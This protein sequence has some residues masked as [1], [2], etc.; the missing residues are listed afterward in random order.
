MKITNNMHCVSWPNIS[1]ESNDCNSEI[2][3]EDNHVEF[4]QICP[5]C[6]THDNFKISID[7]LQTQINLYKTAREERNAK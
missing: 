3:I 4:T 6:S 2:L 5:H 7:M 1:I